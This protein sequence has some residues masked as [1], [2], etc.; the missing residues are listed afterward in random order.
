MPLASACRATKKVAAWRSSKR[1]CP[2]LPVIISGGCQFPG[3]AEVGAG[4][5]LPLDAGAFAQAM[6]RTLVVPAAQQRM[7]EAGRRLIESR[8]SWSKVAEQTLAA[9][10]EGV[11]LKVTTGDTADKSSAYSE[12]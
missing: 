10:R 4:E 2:K 8:Y 11:G 9:Y 3:V 7:A 5:V 12:L 6:E 1:W